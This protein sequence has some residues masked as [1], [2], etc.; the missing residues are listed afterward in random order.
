MKQIYRLSEIQNIVRKLQAKGHIV[1]FVPT[2]GALHQ[3]HISLVKKALQ[4]C[5]KVVVSIF[6][7]PTQFNNSKDLTHYP[8][9]LKEDL[10]LLE[11][12]ACDY[13]FTPSVEEMYPQGAK[14]EQ[15]DFGALAQVME[16]ANR[17]GHFDGVATI[18]K[19]LF[20]AVPAQKAYFGEKDYQQLLII[21]AMVQQLQWPIAIKAVPIMREADGLAM[22]SRNLRLKPEQRAAAPRIYQALL[23]AKEKAKQLTVNEL[24]TAV[25][26]FIHQSPHLKLEYFELAD[27]TNLQAI[28]EFST[29][30][31]R[32]FIVV[33]AGDIRLI[34]NMEIF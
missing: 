32:A 3:G 5:D 16:G 8:R 25:E 29:Q 26:E 19:R 27:A 21:R 15:W 17:P 18:V 28:Q 34:D 14:A 9:T 6:V 2:M 7:N 4:H 10:S 20:E 24:K 12:E 11:A 13:V 22:S 1:G 31:I 30:N 33:H 23:M